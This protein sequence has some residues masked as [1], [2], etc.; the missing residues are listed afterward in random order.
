M[1]LNR[2]ILHGDVMDQLLTIPDKTIDCIITSP[3]YWH[4][5]DYGTGTWSGSNDP[6]CKHEKIRYHTRE[7]RKG[8]TKVQAKNKGSFGS[9]AKWKKTKCPNCQAI[10]S[11]PQLG[12]EPNFRD[13]LKVMNKI[14]LQLHRVLKNTGSCWI[15]LG[16][17]Y[18]DT[19]HQKNNGIHLKSRYG[20]PERFY[21]NCIDAGWT[22]R[23]HI[24][25]VKGNS[26][27]QSVKDRFTNKWES[28]FFFT[29]QQKYFFDINMVREKAGRV[30]IPFNMRARNVKRNQS[31]QKLS[32]K[33]SKKEEQEYNSAGQRTR[34]DNSLP[35]YPPLNKQDST[36]GIDGKP[37]PTY[38]GFNSR[39]Q[40]GAK[41][42]FPNS[43][44]AEWLKHYDSN[45]NC[46]GCGESW[47]KH[48][49]N[50]GDPK[51]YFYGAKSRTE[52]ISWCNQAGKNPADVFHI[53]TS[54]LKEAHFATFPIN[55]PR[56]ILACACPQ[57]VCVK[58]GIPRYPI[59]KPSPAY[60]ELLSAQLWKTGGSTDKTKTGST[61]TSSIKYEG[62]AEYHTTGFT[63]CNCNKKFKSGIVL[64]PF[65]GA[66][67]VGAAA[68]ELGFSWVGIEVKQEYIKM[69]KK[70][71]K[72]IPQRKI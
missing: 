63:R 24:P 54:P 20:I 36:L 6:K 37:I 35:N 72:A 58:C 11:D 41:P 33:I 27:P 19:T 62:M 17:K 26:A 25:W 66:G 13:Y 14:M 16:D 4:M 29:K 43:D 18:K 10:L 34:Q 7:L 52:N 1:N 70:K 69:A 9:E 2:K 32:G 21:A 45:G 71:I 57:Q 48:K 47:R 65:F 51:E 5:R 3:P 28:I 38:K 31:N 12:L 42:V 64:D 23:N 67:T 15:N 8:I 39:W 60:Q 68:E 59:S 22:A 56:K 55:L 61:F 49:V 50:N 40:A 53:N 44:K 30:T 46:L